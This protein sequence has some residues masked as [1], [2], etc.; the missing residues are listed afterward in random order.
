[1]PEGYFGRDANGHLNGLLFEKTAISYITKVQPEQTEEEMVEAMAEAARHYLAEGITTNTE[2][3]L[4]M[5]GNPKKELNMFLKAANKGSN[6]LRTR[7]MLI[8]T[9]LQDA[10]MY[11]GYT[12]EG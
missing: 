4:G 11:A 2:A 5:S 1:P 8:H 3:A 10:G 12:A 9:A 7:L 6:P